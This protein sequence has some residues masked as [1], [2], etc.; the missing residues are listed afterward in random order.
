MQLSWLGSGYILAPYTREVK[1]LSFGHKRVSRA[2]RVTSCNHYS[3]ASRQVEHES[4]LIHS[5]YHLLDEVL[6]DAD[7]DGVPGREEYGVSAAGNT[8]SADLQPKR[9][10]MVRDFPWGTVMDYGYAYLEI[11]A[12][13]KLNIKKVLLQVNPA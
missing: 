5:I 8:D 2:A 4:N 6:W 12:W 1:K 7:A 11:L 10:T 9:V 3:K 13:L